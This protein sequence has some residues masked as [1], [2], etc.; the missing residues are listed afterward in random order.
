MWTEIP[1]RNDA[2]LSGFAGGVGWIGLN[3]YPA[4]RDLRDST[5]GPPSTARSWR[6]EEASFEK[7]A[8]GCTPHYQKTSDNT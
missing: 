8:S 4:A 1:P 7:V 2:P 5:L 6:L 3:Y